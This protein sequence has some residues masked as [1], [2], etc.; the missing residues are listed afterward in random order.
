MMRLLSRYLISGLLWG[1]G[2]M[3]QLNRQ[4]LF[5]MKGQL[6]RLVNLIR[7]SKKT[8]W[9]IKENLFWAF[10]YNVLGIPIAF[11]VLYP[12]FGIR[13]DPMFGALAMMLSSI[14]V[15]SNSL[16]LKLFKE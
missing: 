16:R 15:V 13:L 10:I 1:K 2:P 14:S 5:L 3:L 11:G 9:V 8:L 4:M 7:L 12:F 6:S